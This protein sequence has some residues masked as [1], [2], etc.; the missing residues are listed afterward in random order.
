[1][2]VTNLVRLVKWPALP[3]YQRWKK[4]RAC[5]IQC[6]LVERVY[7]KLENAVVRHQW[8]PGSELVREIPFDGCANPRSTTWNASCRNASRYLLSGKDSSNSATARRMNSRASLYAWVKPLLATMSRT[9]RSTSLAVQ[10]EPFT[11]RRS[12]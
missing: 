7:E 5:R 4:K 11:I 3:L 8:P 6:L 2:P 12:G 9:L 10:V 1:M